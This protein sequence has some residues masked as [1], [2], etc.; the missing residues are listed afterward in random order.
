[1]FF[2]KIRA[3]IEPY[4][5]DPLWSA[6]QKAKRLELQPEEFRLLGV[7][8]EEVIKAIKRSKNSMCEDI[9]GI[10]PAT[11]KL[12]P[13]II[14]LPLTWI[15]NEVIRQG[16]VPKAWKLARVL[17]LHKKKEKSK[18]ENYR[19]VSIL[20]SSSSSLSI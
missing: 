11:L 4:A 10:A 15:I 17:P 19:P 18:V 13:D 2:L 1:M 8:E 6:K 5:G 9:F 20:P 3:G 14:A 12:A 16:E 7:S